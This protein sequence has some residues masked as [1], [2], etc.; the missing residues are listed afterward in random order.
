MVVAFQ[1][2]LIRDEKTL[3]VELFEHISKATRD[4]PSLKEKLIQ[5]V[6]RIKKK[7]K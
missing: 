3:G 2:E 6:A 7:A 1:A 4:N 5:E